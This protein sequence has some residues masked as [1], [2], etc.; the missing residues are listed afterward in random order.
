M[1]ILI[2]G[3]TGF[4]GKALVK[5]FLAHGNHQILVLGRSKQSI[6]STFGEAVKR[7]AWTDL[8]RFSFSDWGPKDIFINLCGA[9]LGDK[10]WSDARKSSILESR[11]ETTRLIA[12]V[13]KGLGENSP[14]LLNAS[15]IGIYGLQEEHKNELPPALTEDSPLPCLQPTD[16]LSEVGCQ[17]EA[18][19]K[20]AIAAGTPVVFLRFGVVLGP[21][22]GVYKKLR[23]PYQFGLGGTIGSGNQAFSWVSLHDLVRA[24]D[25]TIATNQLTG[26]VNITAP[27]AVRQSLFAKAMARSLQRPAF[28]TTPKFLL[29]KLFGEMAEELLLKGQHVQPKR[30]TEMGFTFEHDSI[31]KALNYCRSE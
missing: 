1:K 15:A 12:R 24:I 17:W 8:P 11:V 25:F 27:H 18:A 3:G 20:E 10:P 23:R 22:G 21:H 30:L 2:A 13:C 7:L 29:K 31:D 14:R 6:R 26:P 9:N 16:F 28:L 5:H 19:A 4:I